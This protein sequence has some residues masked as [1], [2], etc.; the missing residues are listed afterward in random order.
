LDVFDETGGF[1]EI[2]VHLLAILLEHIDSFVQRCIF[3]ACIV[4]FY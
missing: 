4:A 3:L 1:L 2:F